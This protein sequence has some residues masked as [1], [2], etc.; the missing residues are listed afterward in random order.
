[1]TLFDPDVDHADRALSFDSGLL[2]A[3]T[4]VDTAVR[5]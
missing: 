2:R 4:V 1:M 5:R 3:N